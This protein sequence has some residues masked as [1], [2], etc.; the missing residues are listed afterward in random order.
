M[1]IFIKYLSVI[2]L[3]FPGIAFAK[4][5]PPLANDIQIVNSIKSKIE[6]SKE[7]DV[8]TIHIESVNGKV[9]LQGVVDSEKQI[10]K[11]IKLS[12]SVSLVRFT[13][14]H[15]MLI[16]PNKTLNQDSVI[17]ANVK[18]LLARENIFGKNDIPL[19]SINVE[20]QAGVVSLSGKVSDPEQARKAVDLAKSI[21]G[22]RDV[23]SS[24]TIAR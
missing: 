6:G 15:K 5:I 24:I 8:L 11:L 17:T 4:L 1:Q 21:D 14:T 23:Y 18:G 2:L 3:I 9:T 12:N 7:L 20:T 13:D 16:K 10:R 19:S 22:V